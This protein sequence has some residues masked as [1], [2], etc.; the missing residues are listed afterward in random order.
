MYEYDVGQEIEL[1]KFEI[2][3]YEKYITTDIYIL[4]QLYMGGK[5][6]CDEIRISRY[7]AV[8]FSSTSYPNDYYGYGA[9]LTKEYAKDKF[10]DITDFNIELKCHGDSYEKHRYLIAG[11]SDVNAY[12][13]CWKDSSASDFS[14]LYYLSSFINETINSEFPEFI[15][16]LRRNKTIGCDI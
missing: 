9:R 16:L 7:K 4:I 12:D 1:T 11:L 2:L 8:I 3:D 14:G 13:F 15:S 6:P 10:R 5:I